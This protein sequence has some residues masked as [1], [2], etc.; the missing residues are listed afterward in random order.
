MSEFKLILNCKE[1]M[2]NKA[3]YV[4]E[5]FFNVLGISFE[6]IH[7]CGN[8]ASSDPIIIYGDDNIAQDMKCK[9]VIAAS[10][11]AAD[12]FS[13]FLE[14]DAN[15][16]KHFRFN[17]IE[18]PILFPNDVAQ[19][20]IEVCPKGAVH[21]HQDIIASA[22]FFLSCWQEV[23][24]DTRDGIGRFSYD[25]SLQR[26]LNITNR[27]IVNDYLNILK[28]AIE[29]SLKLNGRPFPPKPF[30]K[31][32]KDFVACLT[33]DIDGVKKWTKWK[34]YDEVKQCGKIAL[35]THQAQVAARRIARVLTSIMRSSDPYWNFDKIMNIE[36]RYGF[37]STFYFF[38]G[39]EHPRDANYSVYD[40]KIV[41]LLSEIQNR[42]HEVGLH[43]S[44][45]SYNNF[46]ILQDEMQNLEAL[47]GDIYSIRQHYLRLDIQKTFAIYEQLGIECDVTL[48]FAEHE[49]FRAGFCFPFH[50][51]NI[52]EDR[53]FDLIEIPLTVMDGTLSA[54]HYKDLNS[55]EAWQRVES[56]L[57]TV[58]HY[59]GCIV[60]LWHNSHFDESELP[61]YTNVYERTLRWIADNNGVGLSVRNL[62]TNI[63]R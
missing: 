26:I 24:I 57:M 34:I 58:R 3:S 17:N 37:S 12:Y 54:S 21:I 46:E 16:V 61:G 6:I 52:K 19:A 49:G 56:L 4:F 27:P 20:I 36:E 33:H 50:P 2:K 8:L 62:L 38:G 1:C 60:L 18:L 44:F 47:V 32:N 15:N 53:R 42:G 35:K 48:G 22:F 14:Y 10:S 9:I 13:G 28:F 45:D 59:G 23:V 51:Y 29:T 30:W 43:G 31:H 39:G 5:T 41:K 40:N 7:N 55:E 25:R 63:C 11:S